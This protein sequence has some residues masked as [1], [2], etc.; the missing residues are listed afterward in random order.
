MRKFQTGRDLAELFGK[1]ENTIYKWIIEDRLFPNAFQVKRGWYV[2][3]GDLQRV[4]RTGRASAPMPP[5]RRST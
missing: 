2:P 1:H 5:H 3:A 4:I